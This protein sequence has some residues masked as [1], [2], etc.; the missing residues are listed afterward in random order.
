MP[1]P[2]EPAVLMADI[3][4]VYPRGI[5]ANDRV[6][7][8][9][10]QGTIHA[11]VGENGAGKTT[12]MGILYGAVRPDEGRIR[13][14]GTDVVLRTPAD[15]V[16]HGI[17]MVTQHS[18]LIPALTVLDSILLGHERACAGFLRRRA[19]A[20]KLDSIAS[21]LR[22]SV[23]WNKR[24]R[25]LSVASLQKAEV[26]R[27][28]YRGATILILDEPTAALAPQEADALYAT[29]HALSE[30][31]TSVIVVT[32][33]LQEVMAHATRVTVLRQGRVVGEK[34]TSQTSERELA[35]MMVGGTSLP[36]AELGRP[37]APSDGQSHGTWE[38]S[39]ANHRI[40]P[41]LPVL[42]LRG[43][44]LRGSKGVSQAPI[45][46]SVMAGEIVGVAG[47]DGN[48][49][50]EL[51]AVILGVAPPFGGRVIV[52][53]IDVTHAPPRQRFAAGLAWCP[54][55]RQTEGLIMQ[56]N[57]AENLL[58][59]NLDRADIGAG[60]LINWPLAF[61]TASEAM[62][63]YGIRAPSPAVRADSLSGG[64]QQKL[65]LTRAMIRR[66]ACL[67]AIQPT[68]GLDIHAADAAFGAIRA[69]CSRG[70]GVVLISLDLDELLQVADR[71]AVLYNYRL[72]GT[73]PNQPDARERIGAMMTTGRPPQ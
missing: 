71:T 44:R 9:V 72:V 29:L 28:L 59:P 48:G 36:I 73:I 62:S 49:Q 38:R 11:V 27:A 68:R 17:G 63:I 64:N 4:K 65:L 31:G 66:P 20:E 33:R 32:H 6:S 26:V 8:T 15:A 23:P 25:E 41:G 16:R 54:E 55:D 1:D 13:L 21:D 51:A 7:L 57:I 52:N 50:R 43:V 47:V 39:E 30:K 3:T 37:D 24:A 61:R 40:R 35:A 46:L 58:L 70:M 19:V 2:D 18:T 56:F 60:P 12:L 14:R 42:E 69:G 34:D 10:Q 22:I 45:D 67:V 53:G 5:V